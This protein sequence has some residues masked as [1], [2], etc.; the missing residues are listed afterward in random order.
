MPQSRERH[1]LYIS[2]HRKIQKEHP[3]WGKEKVNEE[4]KAQLS[5]FPKEHKPNL[6]TKGSQDIVSGSQRGCTGSQKRISQV[7]G[8]YENGYWMGICPVC[9]SHNLMDPKRSYRPEYQCEHFQKLRIPG[10]P[11]E[12]IFNRPSKRL[13][14]E[15]GNLGT[16][17]YL[18]SYSRNKYQFVLYS[19]SP[20]GTRS[21][22]RSCKKN[23]KLQ[24]GP[25][26]IELTWGPD[27]DIKLEDIPK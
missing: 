25:C 27:T 12:F 7:A 14:H 17:K 10:K 1:A 3:E 4:V 6:K 18:L 16:E 24:L 8:F 15:S 9:I 19:V 2:L 21:L 23:E 5:V 20:T 26:E 11:S 13:T 22:V